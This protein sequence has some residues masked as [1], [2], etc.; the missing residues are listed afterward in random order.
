MI[1]H[2]GVVKHIGVEEAGKFE[3]STAEAILAKL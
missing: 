1:V 3:A 2:D